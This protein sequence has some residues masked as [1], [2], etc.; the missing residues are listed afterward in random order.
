MRWARL[1]GTTG[2]IGTAATLGALAAVFAL[3]VP[4]PAFAASAIPGD[5]DCLMDPTNPECQAGPYVP[6]GPDDS[7]CNGMPLSVGCEGGPF[8]DDDT[9]DWPR[10][11][12]EPTG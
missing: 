9:N 6:T 4:D 12:G 5:P 11:P 2:R 1:P 7:R 10:L 8:D 3:N